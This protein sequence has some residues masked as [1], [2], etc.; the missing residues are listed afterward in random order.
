MEASS[1]PVLGGQRVIP[2]LT[3]ARLVWTFL[4]LQTMNEMQYR[5]NFVVRLFQSGLGLVTSLVM[6]AL[7]YARVKVLNGWYPADMIVLVG[8]FTMIGGIVRAF[9]QPNTTQFMEDVRDGKFDHVLMAPVDAQ[10]MVGIRRIEIWQGV[11]VLV[12]LILIS[13]ALTRTHSTISVIAVIAFV[14]TFLLG[15]AML[16][17]FWLIVSVTAFWFI[18][19]DQIADLADG[20][21]QAGRWP[22]TVYPRWLKA[23]V[24]F[25]MPVGVAVTIPA[26]SL[27]MHLTIVAPLFAALLAAAFLTVARLFWRYGVR[28]YTGASS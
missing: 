1:T 14:V 17:S 4:R 19:I 21:Y 24:T 13:A 12:G 11:D 2:A 22:L 6:V 15:T 20:F 3:T 8:V 28:N 7:V 23:A 9:I 27:T 18:R 25:V 5:A 16:Y 10:L 26:E